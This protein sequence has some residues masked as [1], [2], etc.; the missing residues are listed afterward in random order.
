MRARILV[1][2]AVVAIALGLN[3]ARL[4]LSLAQTG[5]DTL[6]AR[7][8]TATSALK[9]QL[10]TLDARLSPRA[11]ASVPDLVEATRAPADPTQPLGNPDEKSLRAAMSALQPEPDLLAVVNPQGA[12][13]SRRS[14][15]AATIDDPL[16]LPLARTASE[17][18]NPAPVFAA[19]DGALFRFAAARVPGNA[20]A[21]V[22]GALIDDRFAMQLKSQLDA[23]VTLIQGGKVVASS[24]PQGDERARLLRW[25]AAPTPGYGVLRVNL[26]FI[27]PALTGKL[28][29]A[30]ARYAVRGALVPLD[31]GVQAALTLPASPYFAWLARYQAFYVVGLALFVL[32]SV[33]WALL[34]RAPVVQVAPPAPAPEAE[35]SSPRPRRS[36]PSLLGTDVGEARAETPPRGEVPWTPPADEMSR[37]R[38]AQPPPPPEPPLAAIEPLDPAE[39]PTPPAG[40]PSGPADNPMWA[41]DPFT[42]TPGQFTA[43]EA[44]PELVSAEEVGL[45]EASPSP[46]PPP[47]SLDPEEPPPEPE[48]ERP[49]TSNGDAGKGEF[50]FAGLLDEAHSQPP[51]EPEPPRPLS[52]DFPDTTAPGRPS[53]ELLEKARS[54][55]HDPVPSHFPG[56]E[57]TR[58]EPVSAA[59]IDKLRERDDEP[60]AAPSPQQGWGSL[61]DESAERAA[62]PPPPPPEA[63]ETPPEPPPEILDTPP[64]QA[65]PQASVTLQDFSMPGLSG[66]EPDPDEQHWRETYDRFRELKSQLGEPADRISFEKFAAKLKKNRSD[67]LAKHNCKGVRFSVYEKEGKAAIKASAIR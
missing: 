33:V 52:Q 49:A 29:R 50:S 12:I 31:S 61:V 37:P 41:A 47:M 21:A 28:P 16:K 25:S 38:A 62:V 42:P 53:A 9:G 34:A 36:A 32:F 67:L 4:S 45:V 43:S 13:V 8:A 54:G 15:P 48:H 19:Y 23:D 66:E 64:T 51:P 58:I 55:E 30:A 3:L 14:R 1:F 7:L 39:T 56:D 60:P 17:G 11:V 20:A 5:E 57:P 10:E 35:V 40:L 24:L 2:A 44:E 22:V 65:P 27:G 6:R 46:P 26:P 18:G 63:P 59:L